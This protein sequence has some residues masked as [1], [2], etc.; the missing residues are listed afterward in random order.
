MLRLATIITILLAAAAL[1]VPSTQVFAQDDNED[2]ILAAF[3]ENEYLFIMMGQYEQAWDYDPLDPEFRDRHGRWIVYTRKGDPETTADDNLP[4]LQP[5]RDGGPVWHHGYT[6]VRVDDTNTVYGDPDGGGWIIAPYASDKEVGNYIGYP[7]ESYHSGFYVNSQYRVEEGNIFAQFKMAIIRDQV[8][9]EVYLRNDDTAPHNVGLRH[10]CDSTTNG[11][12]DSISYPYIPGRGIVMAETSLTGS[13]IPD[14]FE[15][16]DNP[17]NPEVALRNTLKSEDATPPDRVAIGWWLSMQANDWDYTPIPDRLVTDY[18][19]TLWWDPV[20]LNPGESRTIVTYWGMA[21]ASSSW[22]STTG[23]QGSIVRQDP[24][25]VAV[26]GPRALPINYETNLTPEAMLQSNPFKIKAYIYNLFQDITLTNLNVHLTLPQGLEIVSGSAMQ[27]ILAIPPESEAVPVVWEVKANGTTSGNLEY[28]VSVSGTPGLQKTVT[29]SI[30]VPATGATQFK[31]GWQMVSVPFK[32]NDLRVDKALNL[33]PDTYRAA[34][35][36]PQAVTYNDAPTVAPGD[37]LW[38]YSTIDRSQS[39]VARDAR[40]LSGVDSFRIVLYTG[41]N[42]FGNPFVYAIPW[43]RVKVLG[44]AQDG[45]VSIQEAVRRNWIRGTIYWWNALAGEYE[46]TSDP[47]TMLIP[48]QGYWVKALQPCQLIIPPVDQVGGGISGQITRSAQ[49][50][51]IPGEETRTDGWQLNLVAQAG[52]I[53]DSRSVLGTDSRAIDTFDPADIERPPSHEGYVAIS[54]PHKD[55]GPNSGSYLTDIRRSAQETQVWEFDVASDLKNTDV[56]LTWP[57]ISDV[58]KDYRLKLV[59]VDGSVTKYM[60][61]TSSYHYNT[62]DGGVR[63]FKLVAEPSSSSKLLI[64]GLTV[65]SSRALG[66]ATMS[67]N[68]ST[69]AATDVRI[70]SVSGR[71]VRELAKGRGVT[72]GINTLTWNYRD[73]TGEPVPAGSYLLEVVATTPEGEVAKTVRPFLVAR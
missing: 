25:C 48:W 73:E 33:A 19:W 53:V 5:A 70:K 46:Y 1:L 44:L 60:R 8:R 58:P 55:W 21:A 20:L 29:R 41:W 12:L 35:W 43:G 26:Q 14:Y 11:I 3:N 52:N 22:T 10:C 72:R 31:S 7:A 54:F 39:S 57:N 16:Y 42:Q 51:A 56:V 61:T 40:P 2:G 23:V 67:Y 65:N 62:G 9:F 68:L 45:P 32:F 13:D 49:P 69:D 4:L 50:A 64:S 24:F 27:E 47:M 17:T 28:M 38:L 63:R 37:G 71:T 36:D 30:M 34:K 18:G 59:D 66:G 15:M 6:T